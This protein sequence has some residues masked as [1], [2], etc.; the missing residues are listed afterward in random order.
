M[1]V[2]FDILK[3]NELK[4]AVEL[5]FCG[6]MT[7]FQYANDFF[8]ETN[9]ALRHTIDLMHIQDQGIEEGVKSAAAIRFIA[10]LSNF[11]KPEDLAKEQI[12]EMH[13]MLRS[14]LGQED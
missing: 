4:A 1:T 7:K 8:G 14:F 11:A 5:A 13:P 2:D 10:N 12:S 3:R 9:E 6:V